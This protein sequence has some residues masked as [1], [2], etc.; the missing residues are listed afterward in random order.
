MHQI[1]CPHCQEKFI[2]DQSSYSQ[3]LDQVRTQE[4]KSDIAEHVKQIKAQYD[5]KIV[6][7]K[8]KAESIIKDQTLDKDTKIIELTSKI[9]SFDKEK[10]AIIAKTKLEN[11]SEIE[12]KN[13]EL[14][15]LSAIVDKLKSDQ[16]LNELKRETSADKKIAELEN[17]LRLQKTEAELA[18]TALK[19]KYTTQL[20][21]KDE[22]IAFY[23]DFKAKQSTKLVGESLEEHCHIEFNKIRMTSFPNAKFFKDNDITTGSKGDFIYKELDSN[24]NE[25]LSIMFEMKNENDDTATKKKNSHFF[26]ELNKDRNEKKCEY[27][28]LV[29]ML[30]PDNELYNNGIVDVSYE[31]D[32][33]YVIRPQF[34]IPIISLLRNAAMNASQYKQEIAL[35]RKQTV[36]ITDFED[37]LLTFKTAFAK[38][39]DTASKKFKNA[40][41]DIDKSIDRLQKVKASL[42]SSEN[43]LRLA[44]NKADDLSVK[45]LTKHNPTMAKKFE[46]LNK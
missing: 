38:N 10:T 12:R 22:T 40:I 35:M 28:I 4:F 8:I 31:Y 15:E 45:K 19:E 16:K 9:E 44:N 43:N 29:S 39:Y 20:A 6:M 32:K 25:L 2:L 24:G 1:T 3:I 17:K 18:N 27:A 30:E 33:M 36:D 42:L 46:E 11:Q 14:A 5:E 21:T 41:D 13:K 34:F 26:K 37:N 7:A 23:K